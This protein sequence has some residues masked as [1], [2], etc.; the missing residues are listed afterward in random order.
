[1]T[2]LLFDD[3]CFCVYF[4]LWDK[5]TCLIKFIWEKYIYF[6]EINIYLN[7]CNNIYIA[8]INFFI[9]KFSM[10]DVSSDLMNAS[11]ISKFDIGKIS[12]RILKQSKIGCHEKMFYL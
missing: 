7:T 5:V 4:F 12:L 6:T 11:K 8:G 2:C 10:S 9:Y 1:M 3:K